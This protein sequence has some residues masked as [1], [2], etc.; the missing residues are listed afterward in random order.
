VS[1]LYGEARDAGVDIQVRK[2]ICCQ[3][4]I[5]LLHAQAYIESKM[6]SDISVEDLKPWIDRVWRD[7]GSHSAFAELALK[8]GSCYHNTMHNDNMFMAS[9]LQH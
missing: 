6:T 2:N 1:G 4:F 9:A 3:K 8:V 5:Y 7:A